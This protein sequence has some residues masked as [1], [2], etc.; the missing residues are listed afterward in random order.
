MM[1]RVL[2]VA[3]ATARSFDEPWGQ[4]GIRS[5]RVPYDQVLEVINS[6]ASSK[7]IVDAVV[8][9]GDFLLPETG[10][11]AP[12]D[13]LI[14]LGRSIRD[15]PDTTAMFDGKKWK[16]V[17]IIMISTRFAR[18]DD[19]A[20]LDFEQNDAVPEEDEAGIIVAH[21]GNNYGADVIKKRVEAYREAVLSD[22]DNMGFMVR[23]DR[24]R[25]NVAPALRSRE[26]LESRYYF[27][28]A[29]RRSSDLVIVHRDNFGIQ[30]EVEELEALINRA[31]VSER[32]LQDFFEA[33]PYFL[34]A[35]HTALPQVRLAKHD[36]SLLIPDFILKPIVAQ[37]RDSRWEVLDLK[38]PQVKLIAG[39]GSRAKL[40]SKVMDAI[41]QLRDY[42]E[43][44][45]DPS[46]TREIDTL[47][48]H[49]LKRPK[50]GVLI[51]RLANT[52][53]EAL[54][55]EQEYQADVRV[56]TYDE[57]LEQQQSLLNA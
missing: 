34:S 16:S 25:Y 19:Q 48:G 21:D 8:I 53:P 39:K 51:G 35:M 54:E 49:P 44:F 29:D 40:S 23:Y 4:L 43:H 5:I 47:L 50:L 46:H 33:H 6:P 18:D 28:P 22:L 32:E 30:I 31:D 41:R 38:L 42:K 37:Q 55:R 13:D 56:V 45:E 36:G 1:L 26:E 10:N 14:N 52:D 11:P 9:R 20:A 2:E 27:G 24:G 7:L 15:L 3:R 12:I 17:P 57:I